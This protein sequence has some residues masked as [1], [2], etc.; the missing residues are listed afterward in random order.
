MATVT[1]EAVA[2][3]AD[4]L[5]A[6]GIKVTG[7]NIRKVFGTRRGTP[8]ELYGS[9][10]EVYPHLKTWREKRR[11]AEADARTELQTREQA[12]QPRE[13]PPENVQSVESLPEIARILDALTNAVLSAVNAAREAE[14]RRADDL[15]RK[16]QESTNARLQTA[17]AAFKARLEALETAHRERVEELDNETLEEVD[18]HQR[19]QERLEALEQQMKDFETAV[20]SNA[21]RRLEA[22]R[23][24]LEDSVEQRM[25]N[26][27]EPLKAE[28]DALSK[29]LGETRRN[30]AVAEARVTDLGKQ[31]GEKADETKTLRKEHG[32]ELAG[33]RKEAADAAKA[34]A[35]AAATIAGL[36]ATLKAERDTVAALTAQLEA[37]AIEIGALRATQAAA[38]VKDAATAESSL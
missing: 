17:E 7:E 12:D 35:A 9:P 22:A 33:V 6:Q 14:S 38:S 18:A 1:Y 4:E 26:A 5:T 8:G 24:S 30:L 31:L 36:E 27:T 3:I 13:K 25:H 11:Q 23:Q 10:N 29:Q 34:A 28:I 37:R 20:Q 16:M 15:I 32:A 21:D 2:E 19:T